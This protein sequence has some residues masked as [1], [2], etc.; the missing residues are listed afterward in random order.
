MPAVESIRVRIERA[1]RA[2]A[3][4]VKALRTALGLEEDRAKRML[5]ALP[6]VVAVPVATRDRAVAALSRAGIPSADGE[7]LSAELCAMHPRLI[8]GDFC[9]RCGE[10]RACAVCL[11]AE[12]P[13]LCPV[14]RGRHRMWTGFYWLRVGALAAILGVVLWTTYV[15]RWRIRNWSR[16]VTVAIYPM[17]AEDS[18]V[19][20]AWT[21]G[22][23]G[24]AFTAVSDFF[25]RE[26]HRYGIAHENLLSVRVAPSFRDE[27]PPDPP[28]SGKKLDI[29]LWS[30]NL[31]R[32]A[33]TMK[34]RHGLPSADAEVFVLYQKEGEHALDRSLAVEKFRV[35]IVHAF[36][37]GGNAPWT[38]LAVSH[39]LLHTVGASDKYEASG[40]PV[41]P[42]GFADPEKIPRFPQQRC[43]VMA[44]QIADGDRSFHQAQSVSE[45]VVGPVTAR[46]IGWTK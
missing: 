40:Y 44:G 12:G 33:F 31:R 38:A 45:C 13:A 26:G 39:E 11:A 2:N 25:D 15:T 32:W 6:R 3:D 5:N 21:D 30:L 20:T 7:K 24:A 17:V 27:L 22:V 37:G 8:A 18:P 35:G 43:E 28:K 9:P 42:E 16:P 1:P 46:E 36:A 23:D 41:F 14:C 34:H 4:A 19:V 10:R 29:A